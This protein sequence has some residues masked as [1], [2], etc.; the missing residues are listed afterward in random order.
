MARHD[1]VLYVTGHGLG[2]AARAGAVAEAL[3]ALAGRRLR[4]A[5]RT[6]GPAALLRAC[7]AGTEVLPAPP[8]ELDPGAV[9]RTALDVDRGAT[10]R[11][12]AAFAGRFEARAAEEAR[13]LRAVGARVV[14]ADVAPLGCAAAARAGLPALVV[15]NFGWD[16]LLASWRG[17]HPELAAPLACYRAAYAEALAVRLPLHAGI[18]AFA[19]RVDAGHVVR[20]ARRGREAIRRG[21]GLADDPR[22]LLLLSVGAADLAALRVREVEVGD[23]VVAAFA[24]PPPGTRARWIPLGDDAPGSHLEILA[25]ADAVLAKP[26]YGTVAEALCRRTRFLALPREGWPETAPLLEGLAA[27]GVTAPLRREAFVT[28]RWREPLEALLRRP[29]PRRAPRDD[30]AWRAARLALAHL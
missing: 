10:A 18:E 23:A 24:P 26:G 11:A 6:A 19:R 25:A 4:I 28:G 20:A 7:D 29:R 2:H 21:L 27:D 9:Q 12:H 30:G 8:A 16:A 5:A 14:V 22:P 13:W 17:A 15:G 3:R 1:V